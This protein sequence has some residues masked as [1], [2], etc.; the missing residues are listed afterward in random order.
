MLKKE[1]LQEIRNFLKKSK[2]PLFFFDDDPDGLAAALTLK[3]SIN[4]GNL[5]P[6]K[7]PP[8]EETIYFRKIEEYNPDTVFILDRPIVSQNV[9]DRIKVPVI[10]IDHHEPLERFNVHYYN[11]MVLDK[12]DNRSTSFW[13][14]QVAKKNLWIAMIGIIGDWYIP[15]FIKKFPYKRLLNNKKTPPAII[16]D[17]DFGKLIGLF[18]F[19]LK[20]QTEDVKQSLAAIESI[21]TPYQILNQTTKHGKYLYQRYEKINKEYQML[22]K[23]AAESDDKQ[24]P[25]VFTYPSTKTSFTGILSN[26]LLYRMKHHETFIIAR[27]KDNEYRISLRGR[28][29]PI[30][31]I[32]KKVL[33]QVRGYGGGH[34]L[35]C[36]ASVHKD[37]FIKFI[38]P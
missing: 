1:Q 16:F 18:G 6:L 31:P 11:P 7:V 8:T 27:L 28:T 19:M 15:P 12:D 14:Y 4:R 30:L 21:K 37:D 22:Y 2:N 36:G 29:K 26:E 17:S 5:V 32:L 9:F 24:E 38:K 34:Q 23:K 3:K 13:A 35:A 10:W 20:G 25:Y 33:L